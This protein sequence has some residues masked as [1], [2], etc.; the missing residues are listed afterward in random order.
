MAVFSILSELPACLLSPALLL[1]H[2]IT[3][4]VLRPILNFGSSMSVSAS[5]DFP[6]LLCSS[7]LN[8]FVARVSRPNHMLDLALASPERRRHHES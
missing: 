5:C 1:K 3:P 8:I 2:E 7:K 4:P 6:P